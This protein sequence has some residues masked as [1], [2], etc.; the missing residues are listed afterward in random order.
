MKT[1][2]VIAGPTASGKTAFSIE[3]AKALNTVIISADSRQFYKEMSI[4]TAAPTPEELL[5]VKHY[6]V[7]N[8]SIEDKYDVADYEREVL[9][10]LDELFKT[11]DQVVMTG[12]SGLFIDAV[13]NGID[14]MPDVQLEVRQRWKRCWKK[15][16]LML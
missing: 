12:G 4:G 8:V 2:I 6:F 1:L 10:L 3:L 7:H 14:V 13:C 11:H 5:Q 15:V 16:E 9:A